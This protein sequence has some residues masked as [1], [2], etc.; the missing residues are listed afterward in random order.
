M[1]PA[2]QRPHAPCGRDAKG[3]Q[4]KQAEHP[5]RRVVLAPALEH[6][7]QSNEKHHDGKTA[8]NLE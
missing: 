5:V 1:R 3:G 8:K 7:D 2:Q 4:E 6:G